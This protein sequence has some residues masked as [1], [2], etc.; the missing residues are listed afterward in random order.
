MVGDGR[1]KT[2]AAVWGS[3][4]KPKQGKKKLYELLENASME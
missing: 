1:I 4:E 2:R 3:V